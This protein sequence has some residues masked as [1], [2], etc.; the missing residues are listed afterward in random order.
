MTRRARILAQGDEIVTGATLDTNS[1]WLAERLWMRGVRVLEISAVPD[2]LELLAQQVAEAGRDCELIVS[3]G[4]LGP[5]TDDCTA[6]AVAKALGVPLV[7]SPE[8][9]EQIRAR[10]QRIGRPMGPS[11]RKQALLPEGSTLLENPVGTAPGF[12]VPIGQARAFFFPGVP[13]E[14]KAMAEQHLLGWL[15]RTGAVPM[16]RRRFHVSGVG[17]SALQDRL[18][19][20]VLPEGVRIGYKTWLPY[21]S[22]LLY[23][24]RSVADAEQHFERASAEVRIRLGED[25]FGEDDTTLPKAL[26]V[27][28]RERGLTLALAESCTAG[29]ACALVTE[30]AGSSAWF[31]GGVVS[32][33]DAIKTEVLGVPEQVLA[34]HGAVSEPCAR[35]MAEGVRRITQADI[36]VSITGIAGPDGGSAEKPVGT[37]CFGM[38]LPTQTLSRTTLFGLPGRDRVRALAAAAALEWTRRRLLHL[39]EP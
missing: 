14:L 5:T 11:N 33:A 19:S 6:E 12:A 1:A 36:G 32:Y 38:A 18:Q 28:L 25:V 16:L 26:G 4:G 8:G 15:D 23:G 9:L 31:R 35:A 21:N 39:G 20:L 2:D 13:R 24:D 17:E 30:I 22:I 29:G 37:V 3:G 10:F 7:E 34:E 27:A